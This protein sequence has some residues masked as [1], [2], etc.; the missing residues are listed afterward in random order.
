MPKSTPFGFHYMYIFYDA[1]SKFITVYFGKTTTGEEML[2]VHKQFVTDY[3]R[4]MRNGCVEEW[5]VD[6]GPEFSSA[7]TA[8]FCNEMATARYNG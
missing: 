5:Y 6:G 7:D 2:S 8:K 1:F 4:Y 3:G